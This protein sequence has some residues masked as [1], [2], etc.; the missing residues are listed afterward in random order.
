LFSKHNI[1]SSL[2]GFIRLLIKIQHIPLAA[3]LIM[4][5]E[6]RL[7]VDTCHLLLPSGKMWTR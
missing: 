7:R 2:S 6:R 3:T 4:R 5:M 1:T